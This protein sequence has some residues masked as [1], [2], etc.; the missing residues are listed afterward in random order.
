MEGSRMIWLQARIRDEPY[1]PELGATGGSAG[2][3]AILPISLG[4]VPEDHTVNDLA[5]LIVKRFDA[6]HPDKGRLK[7][8]YLQT[9]YGALMSV[10]DP[11]GMHFPKRNGQEPERPFTVL[12]I[13]FPPLPEELQNSARF[14]S[15]AP[16]S[17]ARPY[18]RSRD[19]LQ[20]TAAANQHGFMNLHQGSGFASKRQRLNSGGGEAMFDPDQPI[21]SRERDLPTIDADAYRSTRQDASNYIIADSQQ[22]PRPNHINTYG[23][24][25]SLSTA[26]VNANA[27]HHSKDSASVPDSP[28]HRGRS[29]VARVLQNVHNGQDVPKSESPEQDHIVYSIPPSNPST[30]RGETVLRKEEV[31]TP[32]LMPSLP[33]PR[34]RTPAVPRSKESYRTPE[35]PRAEFVGKSRFTAQNGLSASTLSASKGG[36]AF[37]SRKPPQNVWD[38]VETDEEGSRRMDSPYSA[39][40]SKQQRP[41]AIDSLPGPRLFSYFNRTSTR[42]PSASRNVFGNAG[43][44]RGSATDLTNN[45]DSSLN[46]SIS[47]SRISDY[48]PNNKSITNDSMLQP[49]C[50]SSTEVT[51]EDSRPLEQDNIQPIEFVADL[52]QESDSNDQEMRDKSTIER[53]SDKNLDLMKPTVEHGMGADLEMTVD[54]EQ[55][56]D[57]SS[58]DMAQNTKIHTGK[59][60]IVNQELGKSGAEGMMVERSSAETSVNAEMTQAKSMKAN[61]QNLS[62]QK[63][64]E[65][66]ATDGRAKNAHK[67]EL[68]RGERVR[69]AHK[70]EE[71]QKS[72]AFRHNE[73]LCIG[74]PAAARLRPKSITSPIPGQTP[75]RSALKTS[76]SIRSGSISSHGT[77]SRSIITDTATPVPSAHRPSPVVAS[78]SVSFAESHDCVVGTNGAKESGKSNA[79]AE[80]VSRDIRS[81][82]GLPKTDGKRAE[83]VVETK[84]QKSRLGIK[85][86]VLAQRRAKTKETELKTIEQPK[87]VQGKTKSVRAHSGKAKSETTQTEL[88]AIRDKGKKPIYDPPSPPKPFVLDIAKESGPTEENWSEI[89]LPPLGNRA[90][91]SKSRSTSTTVLSKMKE[92]KGGM[93]TNWPTTLLEAPQLVQT[94]SITSTSDGVKTAEQPPTDYPHRSESVSRSPAREVVSSDSAQSGS[95]SD[96]QSESDSE[97]EDGMEDEGKEGMNNIVRNATPLAS[98]SASGSTKAMQRITPAPAPVGAESGSESETESDDGELP[99]MKPQLNTKSPSESDSQTDDEDHPRTRTLPSSRDESASRS[100]SI[101]DEAERQLQ[102]ENRQSMEPFRSSQ[103]HPPPKTQRIIGT[104]VAAQQAKTTNLLSSGTRLPNQRLHSLSSI[105]KGNSTSM[106]TPGKRL[107]AYK[108]PSIKPVVEP[109]PKTRIESVPVTRPGNADSLSDSDDEDDSDDDDDDTGDGKKGSAGK[110]FDG[111][112]K[113]AEQMEPQT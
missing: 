84:V 53:N 44:Q 93:L 103:M 64:I 91:P 32:F 16:E 85:D 45:E 2:R 36:K 68:E 4:M 96:S 110:G 81:K 87:A 76:T 73:K 80:D 105:M 15:V 35:G 47:I 24:P 12:A 55:R 20:H 19:D 86:Y 75:R 111:L 7:V 54:D 52:L 48:A 17:S 29:P 78:R 74:S 23:T 39:K 109:F 10:L 82:D 46:R 38:V 106:V 22:S 33:A 50:E 92:T 5:G 61:T 70:L 99:L 108:P 14:A 28:N 107:P 62:Q 59:G 9:E 63:S 26:S 90:G 56:Y 69:K 57:M 67:K 112:M 77:P 1:N 11:V 34:M 37:S 95:D 8:R 58:T 40:R 94:P 83:S 97:S 98:N 49:V 43:S 100:A 21:R 51:M 25:K 60:V 113:L 72:Q 42:S 89:D 101:V 3:D 79:S 30:P 65:Q 88:K 41:T 104:P 27:N 71:H 31:I 102:R 18:K 66:L 6:V 13:R